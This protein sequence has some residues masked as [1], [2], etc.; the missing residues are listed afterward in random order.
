MVEDGEDDLR[1]L[2]A[3]KVSWKWRRLRIRTWRKRLLGELKRIIAIYHPSIS[4][5]L[6]VSWGPLYNGAAILDHKLKKAI[7]H[8]QIP[9]DKYLTITE[10]QILVKYSFPPQDLPYFIL[11]HEFA[12]ILDAL[13]EIEASG[14][15][16]L[17]VQQHVHA[18]MAK[19]TGNYRHLPFEQDADHFAYRCYCEKATKAC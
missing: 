5:D 6:R 10:Q 16:G 1:M 11:F 7:I 2:K 3:Y 4:F 17:F 19:Q 12:H 18:S 13:Q 15:Q 14:R 8:I 9:Y